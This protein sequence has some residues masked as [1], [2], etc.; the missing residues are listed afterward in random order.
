MTDQWV[1]EPIGPGLWWFAPR[2]HE[3][4]DA[5]MEAPGWGHAPLYLA[6]VDNTTGGLTYVHV[7]RGGTPRKIIGNL[8]LWRKA[9]VE[10]PEPPQEE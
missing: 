10:P 3:A 7:G 4:K 6:W 1:P 8:G 2:H 9:E 5:A